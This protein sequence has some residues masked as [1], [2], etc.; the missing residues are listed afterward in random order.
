LAVI[1]QTPEGRR[2]VLRRVVEGIV[3]TDGRAA[4]EAMVLAQE[5]FHVAR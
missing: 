3:W 2:A 5:L 1:G 4:I